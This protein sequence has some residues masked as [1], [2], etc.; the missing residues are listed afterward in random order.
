MAEQYQERAA[1]LDEGEA[2]DT[3]ERF[4]DDWQKQAM[5]R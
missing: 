3:E 4:P 1:N 5:R 2:S